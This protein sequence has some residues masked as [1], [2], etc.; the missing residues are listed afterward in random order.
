MPDARSK[1]NSIGLKKN[2]YRGE[3]TTLCAGCGHISIGSQI[4]T[5]AFEL[6]IKPERIAKI[7]G[8]GCSSKSPAYF[9]NRSFAFN[10]LHGR[11]PSIAS[12]AMLANR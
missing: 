10:G 4:I 5:A 8:I 7:S 9:M 6:G 2:D 1:S 3:T 11:M 12:G